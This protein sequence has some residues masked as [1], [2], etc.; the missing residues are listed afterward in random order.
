MT[1]LGLQGNSVA[2]VRVQYGCTSR[3]MR[4]N[5]KQPVAQLTGK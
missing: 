3:V 4:I 2:L 1:T 5:E